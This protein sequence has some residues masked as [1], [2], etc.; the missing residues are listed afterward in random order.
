MAPP[1]SLLSVAVNVG[2]SNM[3]P[4]SA[5][6]L[7]MYS[8]GLSKAMAAHA[9]M[10]THET[11]ASCAGGGDKLVIVCCWSVQIVYHAPMSTH[12]TWAD[13]AGGGDHMISLLWFVPGRVA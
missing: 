6:N 12:E 3:S 11:W 9:P 1:F 7:P 8:P 4:M 13:C 5:T 10:S 2:P